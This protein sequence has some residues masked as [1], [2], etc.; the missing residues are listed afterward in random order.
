MPP[1][2][3]FLTRFSI[4]ILILFALSL[5]G[6]LVKHQSQGDP[7]LGEN[8]GKGLDAYVSFLDL[9]EQ[10]V[11]EVQ[12]LPETF[13]KTDRIF[14]EIH[15]LEEDLFAL[16]SYSNES[17]GRTVEI[18]N[19][20][21]EESLHSWQIDNPYQPHDRIMDPLLLP[22]KRLVYSFNGV[23][24][25]H[26]LDSTGQELWVQDSIV[27]HHALNTDSAGNIWACTYTKE[28]DWYLIYKGRY[29]VDSREIVYIDNA[30]SQLDPKTGR[31]L[32]HRSVSE[33]LK[34]NNLEHLILKSSHIEDPLHLNDVQPALKTT[35]WYREGDLFLSFRSCSLILQYRPSEDKVIRQL[36]GPFYSQHDVDFLNDST[37]LIFNNNA[38]TFTPRNP[39][40]WKVAEERIDMGKF[41][42]NILCYN[43]NSGE[44]Q[45]HLPDSLF[46]AN[47]I[48]TMTEGMQEVLPD[49]R[50]WIEEQNDGVLWLIKEGEVVYKNVLE[51]PH[52]G[53][54]HLSNW[55]RIL[56]SQP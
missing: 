21:S 38:H 30:I 24:G 15:N 2:Q 1:M 14:N 56:T 11:E 50:I 46:K 43:L 26:C 41:Y 44:Y 13:V 33:L 9:F 54:H 18:L 17:K 23:S 29:E 35:Q 52:E 42:S 12:K 36:E 32:F 53:Y 19:L 16:V 55:T 49:G 47:Q 6:W 37:L 40:N 51:S 8:L 4:T 48:F 28:G 27:H 39:N 20:R 34:A 25:L 31:L 10:S 7:L 5:F 3:K 22:G 45:K